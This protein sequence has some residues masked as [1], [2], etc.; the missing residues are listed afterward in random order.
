MKIFN[1]KDFD[2]WACCEMCMCDPP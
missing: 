1:L 2:W